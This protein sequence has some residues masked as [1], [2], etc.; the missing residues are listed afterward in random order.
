MAS[1]TPISRDSTLAHEAPHLAGLRSSFGASR[2]ADCALPALRVL[3]RPF[4]I[5]GPDFAA[6]DHVVAVITDSSDGELPRTE[7]FRDCPI[8]NIANV[9]IDLIKLVT[10]KIRD[11]A[12]R[13]IS[14]EP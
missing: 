7:F 6:P 12:R 5:F 10:P 14:A 1:D 4:D 9:V 3:Q 2:C 13:E 11:E 8:R